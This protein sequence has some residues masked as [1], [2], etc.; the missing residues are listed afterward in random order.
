MLTLEKLRSEV[1]ELTEEWGM[2]PI[3]YLVFAGQPDEHWQ[4]WHPNDHEARMGSFLLIYSNGEIKR[5]EKR[6]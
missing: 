4:I 2:L 5:A 1:V 6:Q 3:V